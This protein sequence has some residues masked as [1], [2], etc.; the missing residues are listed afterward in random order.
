MKIEESARS[1]SNA[2]FGANI[3]LV[4][5]GHM[6]M[7]PTVY[8]PGVSAIGKFNA[9][10]PRTWNTLGWAGVTETGKSVFKPKWVARKD[11]IT[12]NLGLSE[13]AAEKLVK[14]AGVAQA[15]LGVGI[16]EGAVEEA[17]QAYFDIWGYDYTMARHK[18]PGHKWTNQLVKTGVDAMG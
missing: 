16:Y 17:G 10:K 6:L 18:M 7:L 13:K 14:S 3:V 2:V 8:G 5:T 1:S 4:G 15:G 9:F 12:K 11:W